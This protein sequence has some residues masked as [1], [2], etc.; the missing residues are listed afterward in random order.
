MNPPDYLHPN[1]P[2]GMKRVSIATVKATNESLRGYGCL[3]DKPDDFTVEIVRW[4]PQ[5]W[6]PVDIDSGN[7]GGTTEGIFV[8]E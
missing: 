7:E 2:S 1:I 4:P 5:G 6:R 3:V 8:S